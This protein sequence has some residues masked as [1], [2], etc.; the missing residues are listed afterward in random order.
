[1]DL[2]PENLK[3]KLIQ[4]AAEILKERA[5]TQ[6]G[7]VSPDIKNFVTENYPTKPKK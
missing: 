6:A 4:E 3:E 2:I 1:M 7:T 5:E